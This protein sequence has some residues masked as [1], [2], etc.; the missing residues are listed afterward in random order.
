MSNT[1]E[2]P[3]PPRFENVALS[4]VDDQAMA[5]VTM[6][7]PSKLNATTFLRRFGSPDHPEVLRQAEGTG[8]ESRSTTTPLTPK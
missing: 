1:P 7:R 5:I 8:A 6:S 2:T 3:S 4:F